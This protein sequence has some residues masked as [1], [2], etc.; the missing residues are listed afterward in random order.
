MVSYTKY[1]MFWLVDIPVCSYCSS[2]S[3]GNLILEEM[4]Y[5]TVDHRLQ[6]SPRIFIYGLVLWLELAVSNLLQGSFV[7]VPSQ[8][9][10]TLHCNVVS[11]WLGAYTTWSLLLIICIWI[12][13]ILCVD[14][15]KIRCSQYHIMCYHACCLSAIRLYLTHWGR[16]KMPAFFQMTFS[17]VFSWMKMFEFR[18]KLYWILFLMV[19]LT[20]FRHWFR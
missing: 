12:Y 1:M 13:I 11:H 5:T 3:C 9:E 4:I 14:H 17:N 18:L 16:D 10:M 6:V 15:N 20:I 8:W 7:N 19:Q 2:R